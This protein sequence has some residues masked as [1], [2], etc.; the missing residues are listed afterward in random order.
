M[1]V[2]GVVAVGK[3]VKW[4]Q[5]LRLDVTANVKDV[6]NSSSILPNP[7]IGTAEMVMNVVGGG[8]DSVP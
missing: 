4:N 1:W 3:S 6:P 8:Q 5:I 2:T 7:G